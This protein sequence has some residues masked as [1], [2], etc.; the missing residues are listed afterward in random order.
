MKAETKESIS[1]STLTDSQI[2]QFF[3][4]GYDTT[5]MSNEQLNG[6]KYCPKCNRIEGT[7][8]EVFK[9][10]KNPDGLIEG[11]KEHGNIHEGTNCVECTDEYCNPIDEVVDKP[12]T[13]EYIN[14]HAVVERCSS[15][16][17]YLASQYPPKTGEVLR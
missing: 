4:D 11:L 2:D 8:W 14:I 15:C 17:N 10:D 7:Y 3:E 6:K 9:C 1:E 13:R 16:Q 12:V 5:T